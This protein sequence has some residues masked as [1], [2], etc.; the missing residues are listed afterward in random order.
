MAGS[1]SLNYRRTLSPVRPKP[2][3]GRQMI[4]RFSDYE[5]DTEGCALTR[6]GV[7]VAVEAQVFS[8]LAVLI[9]NRNRIVSRDELIETVWSGRIISDAAISSRIHSARTAIGDNGRDQ[10]LIKT[11]SGRGYRFVGR[12]SMLPAANAVL[13]VPERALSVDVTRPVPGFLDRPAIVLLPFDTSSDA[14]PDI[15]LAHGLTE[16]LSLR[17]GQTGSFP[18]ISSQSARSLKTRSTGAAEIGRRLGAR[19]LLEGSIQRSDD[20]LRI[21]VHLVSALSEERLWSERYDTRFSEVFDMQDWV[22]ATI[23]EAL[24]REMIA[25]EAGPLLGAQTTELDAWQMYLRGIFFLHRSGRSDNRLALE[26]FRAAIARDKIYGPAHG[27]LAMA[28]VFGHGAG[29]LSAGHDPVE[30]MAEAGHTAMHLSPHEPNGHIGL[31]WSHLCR[32][33]FEAA[34]EAIETAVECNPSSAFAAFYLAC[35]LSF[36]GDPSAAIDSAG[37][38]LRLNPRGPLANRIWTIQARAHYLLGDYERSVEIN[39]AVIASDD[40]TVPLAMRDLAASLACLGA[41]DEAAAAISHLM[42][43]SPGYTLE[44]AG[45]TYPWR[46][47]DQRCDYLEHLSRAGLR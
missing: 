45:A 35:A 28:C 43:L 2:C 29:W 7:D 25:C 39:R 46:H 3:S 18:V 32:G 40:G 41:L 27:G 14:L 17:L 47:R 38:A 36:A 24:E 26:S 9:E 15:H 16:E 19:Y 37:R 4:Y 6:D 42:Q 12:A 30:T 1:N 5:L 22:A 44:K 8:T 31:G 34:L 11:F 23:A 20:R 10:A 21:Y 13:P 33:E